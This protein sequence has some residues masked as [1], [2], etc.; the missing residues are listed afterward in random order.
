MRTD[1]FVS[2]SL[3][4]IRQQSKAEADSRA[5]ACLHINMTKAFS[6]SITLAQLGKPTVAQTRAGSA[7]CA[8]RALLQATGTCP[9]IDGPIIEGKPG[10]GYEPQGLALLSSIGH[11]EHAGYQVR[12]ELTCRML[13]SAT[14]AMTQSSEGFQAKSETLDVWP[15][16][17]N[18]SSGG[19]SSASS[20][21]CSHKHTNQSTQAQHSI[22]ASL[23]H[24]QRKVISITR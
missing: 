20:G 24:V 16:W 23:L 2:P 7:F 12:D 21:V 1:H 9:G 15:P 19:P 3:R 22:A 13:S 6:I 5:S 10:A 4:A 17:M 11:H 18:S 14:E 8:Q